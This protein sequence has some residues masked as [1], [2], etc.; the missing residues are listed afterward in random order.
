MFS[1]LLFNQ[2]THRFWNKRNHG[3][4]PAVVPEV[5]SP[6]RRNKAAGSPVGILLFPV[7]VGVIAAIV[8]V[9][10]GI[11]FWLLASPASETITDSGRDPSRPVGN[12]L[13]AGGAVLGETETPH[14]AAV[15]VIPGLPLGQRLA[16]AEAA[17]PQR[18]NIAQE[19]SPAPPSSEPRVEAALVPQPVSSAAV[20]PADPMPL[21]TPAA[22]AAADDGAL[23][24]GNRGPSARNSHTAHART[25]SQHS[26]P[27][28]A[29]AA[30]PLKPP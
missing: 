7:S 26:R 1:S 27:R 13:K 15:N 10:F 18:N 25:V 22:V 14:S 17:S 5:S 21:A 6:S 29:R 11:G 30:S 24:A 9:F 19:L 4:K 12:A 16:A 28:S 8:G 20:S 23:S 3:R 2:R